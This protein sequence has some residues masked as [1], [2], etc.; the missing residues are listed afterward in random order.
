M[1]KPLLLSR[2]FA[3]LFACQFFA[4]FKVSAFIDP[5]RYYEDMDRWLQ[6]LAATKPAP[7]HKR[8]LYAGLAE[9]EEYEKR[10]REGIPYHR[11]VIDWYRS[12]GAELGLEFDLP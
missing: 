3:P 11:E 8:V 5:D 12:I 1:K 4:A 6:G 7:G 9:S 10:S 2:R